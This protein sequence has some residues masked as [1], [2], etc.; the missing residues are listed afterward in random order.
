MKTRILTLAAA[1]L[2]AASVR[3]A[4]VGPE[5]VLPASPLPAHDP[6]IAKGND[7]FLVV[8][9]SGKAEKADICACRLDAAGKPLDERLILVSDGFECQ[10]RPRAAWG[11]DCWL[12]VWADLR[13][14]RD[15]DIFAARVGADGKVLDPK[16]IE[17][18]SGAHNQCRPDVAFNGTS[19]LV[20]WR[21][22]D[23]GR[24]WGYGARVS[25][26]GAV[27]DTTPLK[28]AEEGNRES[29]VGE[30]ALAS[31]GGKWL[32]GWITRTSSLKNP[33]GGGGAQGIRAT[34]VAADGKAS[35]VEV[36]RNRGMEQAQPP[37][38]IVSNG[39]DECLYSWRNATTGGRSGTQR[40][41]PY[42]ALRVDADG[43]VTGTTVLGRAKAYVRQPAAAWDGRG[44]MVVY[45]HGHRRDPNRGY[46]EH[47]NRINAHLIAAD[48]K[49]E[50]EIEI[51]SGTP[52]P[53]YAPD[54]CGA[55]DGRTLVVY[56]RHPA[57]AGDPI[58]IAV[59][60]VTR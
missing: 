20:V 53:G 26:A 7:S 37:V 22:F 32:A 15:Y 25:A 40:G 54:A 21:A 2:A 60:T 1:I 17:I 38:T 29:S 3:A 55:G 52:H 23:Q 28:I 11:R 30:M 51:S 47:T 12:V 5:T 42:G 4:E 24:Y 56:E 57:K 14:D 59:R 45:W 19:W 35:T 10:E 58:L 13:N 34:L 6:R 31:I 41:M 9:Q 27:M 46:K 18:I 36:Y 48:G 8:W 44:Y 33:A 43:K 49:Y 50:K 39:K 16:G